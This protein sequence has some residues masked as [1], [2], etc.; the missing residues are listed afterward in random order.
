QL[1]GGLDSH[2]D[3]QATVAP[4]LCELLANEGEKAMIEDHG[5]RIGH[6]YLQLHAPQFSPGQQVEQRSDRAY[7]GYPR[8]HGG[9]AAAPPQRAPA[10]RVARR[11]SVRWR[12]KT[13][14][15]TRGTQKGIFSREKINPKRKT[16]EGP[17]TGRRP[18]LRMPVQE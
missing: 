14:S 5:D 11:F 7:A 15:E 9:P 17:R 2:G 16:T 8:P 1:N 10:K 6:L 18:A 13:M 4:N 12:P 3:H